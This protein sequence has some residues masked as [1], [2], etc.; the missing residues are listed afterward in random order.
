MKTNQM[1]TVGVLAIMLLAGCGPGQDKRAV[2]VFPEG[3]ALRGR[4]TFVALRCHEC[5]RIDGEAGL[6]APVWSAE[7]V[8]VLGGEVPRPLSYGQLVT[9]VIHPDYDLAKHS[10]MRMPSYNETMTV[11]QMLDL[12][13][14]LQP[15]YKRLQPVYSDQ[16]FLH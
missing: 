16:Y 10:D 3:D 15:H 8:V 6:P 4:E 13:T 14:F 11:G 9:A 2:F 7:K 5:H 1:M 12:V